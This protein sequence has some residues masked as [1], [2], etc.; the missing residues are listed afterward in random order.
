MGHSPWVHQESDT[1]SNE[2]FHFHFTESRAVAKDPVGW[3][4]G[5]RS[6]NGRTHNKGGKQQALLK[7]ARLLNL[8]SHI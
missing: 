1:T 2:H 8:S 4:M 6:N 3:L 5:G 7:S